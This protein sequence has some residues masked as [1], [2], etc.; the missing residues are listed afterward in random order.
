MLLV[1]NEC[2]NEYVVDDIQ[3]C[4]LVRG[5]GTSCTRTCIT[6]HGGEARAGQV[7]HEGGPCGRQTGRAT[8]GHITTAVTLLG[9]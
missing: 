8:H 1:R 9:A 5:D 6:R 3:L 2:L 7:G 4:V